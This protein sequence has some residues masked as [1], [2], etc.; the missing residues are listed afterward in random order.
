MGCGHAEPVRGLR[1]AVCRGAA[2][3]ALVLGGAGPGSA[4]PLVRVVPGESMNIDTAGVVVTASSTA[5]RVTAPMRPDNGNAN[6][7]TSFRRWWHFE[8][9]GFDATAGS[10]LAITMA[11]PDGVALGNDRTTSTSV[12]LENEW[13]Q[14]SRGPTS[15]HRWQPRA[16]P[17]HGRA[18]RASAPRAWR[19]TS[20][21]RGAAVGGLARERRQRG[22]DRLRGPG[23]H[24]SR[25]ARRRPRRRRHRRLGTVHLGPRRRAGAG[26]TGGGVVLVAAAL[27]AATHLRGR[28]TRA[29]GPAA[30]PSARRRAGCAPRGRRRA[31]RPRVALSPPSPAS[32]R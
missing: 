24:E 2:A 31:S 7:P 18:R 8:V 23:R 20:R 5:W 26:R 12:N 3:V 27:T 30:A 19:P 17:G 14:G 11:K 9:V 29:R 10:T 6:L 16:G 21:W 1:A 4:T 32:R 15:W 22:N 25:L 13:A 28:S